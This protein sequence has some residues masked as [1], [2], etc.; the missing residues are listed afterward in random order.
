MD[1]A[2]DVR[3]F[4]EA[5][6]HDEEG[7]LTQSKQL[8]INKIGH[9]NAHGSVLVGRVSMLVLLKSCETL[10]L[11]HQAFALALALASLPQ[12]LS[13]SASYELFHMVTS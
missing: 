1:S 7:N 9:G 2:S 11:F 5:K 6:A 3:C 12:G 13:E 8:S 10:L 4:F